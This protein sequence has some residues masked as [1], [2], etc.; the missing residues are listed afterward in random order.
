MLQVTQERK[1]IITVT[2]IDRL[3]IGPKKQMKTHKATILEQ[4]EAID[5][6]EMK[7]V[8]EPQETSQET[9]PEKDIDTEDTLT[10]VAVL[11]EEGIMMMTGIGRPAMARVDSERVARS[12]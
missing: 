7:Q 8:E 2:Q 10:E 4:V 9:C 6:E 1:S 11:K 5:I 12:P 3:M